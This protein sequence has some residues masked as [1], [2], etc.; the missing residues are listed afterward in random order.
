MADVPTGYAKVYASSV[1]TPD[2][3]DDEQAAFF[4]GPNRVV[5]KGSMMRQ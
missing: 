4:A 3:A 1:P 2:P 5:G